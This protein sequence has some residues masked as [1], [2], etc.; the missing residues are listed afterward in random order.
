MDCVKHKTIL[1]SFRKCEI[2]NGIDATKNFVLFE[3]NEILDSN[4]SNDE[5]DKSDDFRKCYDQ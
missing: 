2:S 1:Q 3:E 4:N 5:C